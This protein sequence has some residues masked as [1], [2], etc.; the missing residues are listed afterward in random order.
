MSFTVKIPNLD[1]A[2]KDISSYAE[3]VQS[4]VKR[5][6][7]TTGIN[8]QRKAVENIN[9]YGSRPVKRGKDKK[10][11]NTQYLVD[12]G[13]MRASIMLT[14]KSDHSDLNKSTDVAS[15]KTS[16]MASKVKAVTGDV[17]GVGTGVFYAIFHEFGAPKANI[18]ARPFLHPAAESERPDHI[19]RMKK[20][21]KL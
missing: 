2:L 3:K 12:T 1:K 5:A 19:A 7:A 17:T 15:Q 13:A 6:K 18:P 4:Q 21:T 16:A 20:A 11:K 8:V 9:S 14:F 10:A